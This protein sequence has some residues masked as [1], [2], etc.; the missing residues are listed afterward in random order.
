MYLQGSQ[1]GLE[2]INDFVKDDSR[3]RL[4]L[5]GTQVDLPVLDKVKETM[6]R[7]GRGQHLCLRGTNI[8][9]DGLSYLGRIITG[10]FSL[11]SLE[12]SFCNIFGSGR[13][14]ANFAAAIAPHPALEILDLGNNYL[15]NA[16]I[17]SL[18]SAMAESPR[19][20]KVDLSENQI[21]GP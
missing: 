3:K 8:G 6:L 16:P 15:G 2:I 19:L 1:V 13:S 9:D 17:A 14:M 7:T 18:A 4:D 21:G 11:V 20:R 5:S 12:L 10:D